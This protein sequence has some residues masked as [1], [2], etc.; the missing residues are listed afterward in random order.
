MAGWSHPWE[1]PAETLI[2]TT[3]DIHE[4]P[5][6]NLPSM[7]ALEIGGTRG[8]VLRGRTMSSRSVNPSLRLLGNRRH[9]EKDST[10]STHL[11]RFFRQRRL[12][13]G[14]RPGQVAERTGHRNCKTA[15]LICLFE[16][17]GELDPGLFT[18]LQAALG[19]TDGE[20]AEQMEQDRREHFQAWL[21]WVNEPVEP[22]LTVRAIPGFFIGH[23]LP[24]GLESLE[25]MEE[26]ASQFAKRFH[27][28]VW[29]T[30]GTR[31]FTVR[32]DEDGNKICVT[33]A[34]PD[35]MTTP[36][37]RLA[38][39]RHKFLFGLGDGGGINMKLLDQPQLP[40]PRHQ[41][42]T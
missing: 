15:N 3:G 5:V 42:D 41:P 35:T 27:K 26:Y 6:P 31:K 30:P 17:R 8:A 14:L 23:R 33:E 32:Y 40:T 19:I 2:S 28:M 25:Q 7:P 37:M 4:G 24:E 22:E 10:V 34:T 11:S 39:G 29:L 38:K 13:L 21:E 12:A 16:E 1:R 20:V 9:L 36:W 18:K